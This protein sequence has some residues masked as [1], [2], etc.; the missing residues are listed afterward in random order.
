MFEQATPCR[1]ARGGFCSSPPKSRRFGK[2]Q[3][4][5]LT[6]GAYC[7]SMISCFYFKIAEAAP[8]C[9]P[10]SLPCCTFFAVAECLCGGEVYARV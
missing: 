2:Q 5:R 7:L 8:D 9:S 6:P 3:S 1:E 10:T 4:P